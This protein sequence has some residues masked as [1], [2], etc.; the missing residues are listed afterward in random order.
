MCDQQMKLKLFMGPH[1]LSC[2]SFNIH[3]DTDTFIL[4]DVCVAGRERSCLLP[5]AEDRFGSC[6]DV[7]N[8]L[9]ERT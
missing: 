6:S 5:G 7:T 2:M 4:M 9:G 8:H 1:V 3:R